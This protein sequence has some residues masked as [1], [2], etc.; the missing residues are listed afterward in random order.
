MVVMSR[1]EKVEEILSKAKEREKDYE[2]A[3]AAKLC[4][5][6]LSAVG[7][8]DFLEKGQVLERIGY[9]LYR[10]A[11]QAESVDEFKDGMRQVVASYEK[12]KGFYGKLSGQGEK[13]RTIRCDA[14]I[15]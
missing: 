11:M 8:K 4:K 1:R 9:A 13:P 6:A 14:M 2:W 5:R 12:A 10:A 15:A 3:K 7:K